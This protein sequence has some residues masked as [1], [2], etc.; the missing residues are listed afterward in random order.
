MKT[1]ELLK[2]YSAYLPYELKFIYARDIP[3]EVNAW[4]LVGILERKNSDSDFFAKATRKDYQNQIDTTL[5]LIKPILYSMDMLTKEIEH[6]GERF[7]PLNKISNLNLGH[8]DWISN[9]RER[10]IEKYGFQDWFGVVPVG[11]VNKLLEWHF[12]VF[13][14]D[15]SEYIKKENL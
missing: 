12:N 10:L 14:L 4:K 8:C 9:E 6:K 7:I 3:S 15:E 13:G 11:I 1:K 2:I 5:S